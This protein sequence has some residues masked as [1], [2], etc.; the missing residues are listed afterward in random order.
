MPHWPRVGE[1]SS[2]KLGL[3]NIKS[4]LEALDNP[5]DK[6]PPVIHV[7][8]TNGKGSTV[9]FLQSILEASGL[10]V[11]VNTSP[12][13]YRFNERIKIGGEEISDRYLKEILEECRIVS[14]KNNINTSFFE[15]ITAAAFLAFS[16][17]KADITLVEVGMGGRLDATNVLTKPLMTV[18]TPI[19]LDHVESLG[20]TVEKIAY[21]KA[22]I[23]KSGIPSVISA[24]LDGAHKVIEEYASKNKVPLFRYEYDFGIEP[25]INGGFQYMSD[26]CKIDL[27]EPSLKGLHQ[28]VNAATAIAAV[29]LIKGGGI[30]DASISEGIENAK[31]PGRIEKI[32]SGKL[33]D[34]LPDGS[35]VY[36]DGAH[37]QSGAQVLATWLSMQPEMR[38]FM[39]VGF[40]KNRNAN[41]FLK[42]FQIMNPNVICSTVHSE[43]LSYKGH[44]LQEMIDCKFPD[45]S[46]VNK[47]EEA[48]RRIVSE[49]TKPVRVIVSGSLFLVSD[50]L[51]A[52]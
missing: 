37:N 33:F 2:I 1:K 34:I 11:H 5:Q 16:R 29:K 20:D 19:S 18:I 24:Q 46:S 28:Y 23:M 43:P 21:E 42:Y 9:S 14:E 10:R 27:P 38:T 45:I 40:T 6:M 49:N 32:N 48:L 44:E 35:E 13:I 17:N 52:N 22:C 25:N 15:G 50:F 41:D 51:R 3:N 47:I 39:V 30:T 4:L 26:D 36:L 8:G 12:H 31:W 7:A